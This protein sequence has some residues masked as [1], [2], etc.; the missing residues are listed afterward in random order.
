[1][2]TARIL[3]TVWLAVLVGF[4]TV[5]DATALGVPCYAPLCD[6]T[7]VSR[8]DAWAVGGVGIWRWNGRRWRRVALPD[9]LRGG[10]TNDALTGVAATSASN[11]WTV[12]DRAPIRGAPGSGPTLIEHWDGK[13]WKRVAS[14][15]PGADRSLAGV[16]AVSRS[17]AWAVGSYESP[18]FFTVPGA[19]QQFS[20]P[21]SATLILHWDGSS[22]T[23]VPSP[24]PGG[25]SG[26]S[27]LSGVA[28]VSGTDAWA[29]GWSSTNGMDWPHA[30]TVIEHWDGSSWNTVPSPNPGSGG[31]ELLSVSATS[32]SNAWAVGYSAPEPLPNLEATSG[33][34]GGV[35]TILEHWDGSSWT[36]I[37]SPNPGG[38]SGLNV[39]TSVSAVSP[40]NAWAVGYYS[41]RICHSCG[42]SLLLHWN[43][44]SWKRLPAPAGTGWLVSVAA[45]S[46]TKALAAGFPPVTLHR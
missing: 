28:A 39:L 9:G 1:M 5:G 8:S 11:A 20:V 3:C 41:P 12:G 25:T 44:T 26:F 40:T 4:A 35:Q 18:R 42:H 21:V 10:Y 6:V 33:T 17:N 24:S 46:S 30:T 23:Q 22:W 43:G 32:A 31:H 7:A 38:S 2:R 34:S 37:P 27:K 15:N 16:A 13:T 19:P 36:A 14:P 29:V 45:V